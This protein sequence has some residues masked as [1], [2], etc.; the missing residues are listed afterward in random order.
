MTDK[1]L[2]NKILSF[3]NPTNEGSTFSIVSTNVGKE[4]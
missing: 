4:Q 2:K 3:F 1:S